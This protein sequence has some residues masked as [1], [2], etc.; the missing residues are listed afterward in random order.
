MSKEQTA[1]ERIKDEV[2]KEKGFSGWRELY[3]VSGFPFIIKI[4]EEEVYP[5]Y[6]GE[7][8]QA[9]QK[10]IADMDWDEWSYPKVTLKES[11]MDPDNI[12]I[13]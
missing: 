4:L 2:A 12:V 13:L 8:C 6:I 1:L 10:K 11:I 5:K 9:T 3:L 7:C